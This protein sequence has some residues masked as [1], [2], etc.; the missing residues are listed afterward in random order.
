[1]NG[2]PVPEE[3]LAAAQRHLEGVS[4]PPGCRWVVAPSKQVAGGWFFIY[5]VERHPPSRKPAPPF[6]FFPGY[7]VSADGS[8]RNIDE[9]GL[10]EL[11]AS[12]LPQ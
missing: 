8:V 6:G 11:F 10:R 4:P 3:V 9:R 5:R 7:L 2:P 12:Q 1:M